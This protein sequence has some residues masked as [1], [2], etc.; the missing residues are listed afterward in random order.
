MKLNFTR[1]ASGFGHNLFRW[2]LRRVSRSFVAYQPVSLQ[3][4]TLQPGQ[5]A[6][7]DRWTMIAAQLRA[8]GARSLLDLGCA[9]GY[10]V[11]SAAAELGCFALGVDGDFTRLLVAQTCTLEDRVTGAAFALGTIDAALV[12]RLP[13]FDAVIFLSVMHHVM[14]EHGVDYARHLLRA[15]HKQTRLCLFFDM[16]QSNET[17]N[18]W[19]RLLPD[20]G[21]DPAAWIGDFLRSAGFA[22]VEKIGESDSWK[23]EARRSVFVARP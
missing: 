15:I 8:T 18:E 17:E 7:T 9:E 19:A 4:E 23:N 5:R 11:R 21:S 13:V 22:T 16:G 14:Y 6:C 12:S 3:G 10:F 1:P 2:S 20:M